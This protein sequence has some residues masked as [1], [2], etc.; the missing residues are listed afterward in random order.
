M[1]LLGRRLHDHPSFFI[2]DLLRLAADSLRARKALDDDFSGSITIE[3]LGG[4]TPVLAFLDDGIGLTE[5]ELRETL[6]T[7]G[8]PDVGVLSCFAVCDEVVVISKSARA[9]TH[10]VVEWRG[11]V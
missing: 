7:V 9:G 2:R 5:E 11:R 6:A 8:Q 10:P 4:Q 3:V 1:D